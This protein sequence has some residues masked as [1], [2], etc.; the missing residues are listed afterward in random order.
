M[1]SITVNTHGSS[2]D[3]HIGEGA[4][5]LFGTKYHEFIRSFDQ[6]VVL[7]DETVASIHLDLLLQELKPIAR[8]LSVKR[9]PAGEKAKTIENFYDCQ[10]FLLEQN[11]TR[12][13]VIVAF[14]GG[15]CGDLAGFVASTFM[16]GIPFI[17]CPTTI[18]A[19]DS[20]V[21]GK[22]A[23][24]HED[25]KNMIGTFYQPAAVIYDVRVLTTLSEQEVRSGM[26]EVI[27]HALISNP[28]WLDELMGISSFDDMT[29]VELKRH[30]AYGI[31]VKAA[32]VEEDE[33]E[34]SVRK[35][36]N[37]G[38]T[39]G[40]AIEAA[41]GYG[42]ITHGEA[43]MLGMVYELIASERFGNVQKGFTDQF[44]DY[45]KH[46]GYPFPTINRLPFVELLKYMEKDKKASFGAVQF[47]LLDQVGKPF[48]Q[49]IDADELERLD[50]EFRD[51]VGETK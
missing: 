38:H 21:G 25:G 47:A 50:R 49:V 3:V 43:V 45:A 51:R 8:Q 12:K 4:Y 26:A 20:A 22:T 31:A 30:L 14:G 17:Q 34:Q 24:N 15:A 7:T 23:I 27:K 41:G 13:S 40:H 37:F 19:H 18:L 28:D 48:L 39:Y 6:V 16:R 35:Y 32:I 44:I 36:L 1:E 46:L 10:T 5:H 2:Y 33:R 9:I 42:S 29:M 11:C